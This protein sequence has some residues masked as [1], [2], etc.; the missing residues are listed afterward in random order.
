M[1]TQFGNAYV[2]GATPRCKRSTRNVQ[3]RTHG[4]IQ[5]CNLSTLFRRS[6]FWPSDLPLTSSPRPSQH[7]PVWHQVYTVYSWVTPIKNTLTEYTLLSHKKEYK[8]SSLS[9]FFSQAQK[10]TNYKVSAWIK[11]TST[12]RIKRSSQERPFHKHHT[13]ISQLNVWYDLH[14]FGEYCFIK[15]EYQQRSSWAVEM[16]IRSLVKPPS[17]NF[18]FSYARPGV[19]NTQTGCLN[20]CVSNTLKNTHAENS[21]KKIKRNLQ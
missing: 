4:L 18:P 21:Q 11:M 14:Y 5:D 1:I 16:N 2:C 7:T 20:L 12:L 10:R 8:N 17:R 3:M 9:L 13:L 15:W 19:S 6:P